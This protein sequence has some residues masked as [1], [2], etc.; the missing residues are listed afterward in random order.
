MEDM[1]GV[2]NIFVGRYLKKNGHIDWKA[3]N[4]RAEELME[5]MQCEVNLHV[6]VKHLRTAEQFR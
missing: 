5:Y 6:A 2:E 3:L 1:T 4:K